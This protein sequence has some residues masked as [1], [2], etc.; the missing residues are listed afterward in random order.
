MINLKRIR[1][2]KNLTMKQLGEALGLAEST[3]SLY[4]SGKRQPDQD[5]L[6]K[7][8]S[9]FDVS[10]DFLLGLTDSQISGVMETPDNIFKI[11]KRKIPVLGT[12]AAGTPTFAEQN[13]EYYVQVGAEIK[14][15][16]C[17]RVKGDSMINARIQDGDLVFIR[18]QPSVNDGEIAAVLIDDEATLKRVYINDNN[19]TNVKGVLRDAVYKA[20]SSLPPYKHMQVLKVRSVQ[21]ERTTTL[22][23]KRE[24]LKGNNEAVQTVMYI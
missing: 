16:F 2:E 22:K 11:E 24:T 14:A 21:F 15:D 4:E 6:R 12:I 8:S 1:L 3:I 23:I 13:F 17:L 10:T 19:I 18:Q 20:N 9:Y 5:T 7:L